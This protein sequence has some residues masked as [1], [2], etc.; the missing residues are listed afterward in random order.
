MTDLN[1]ACQII[2]KVFPKAFVDGIEDCGLNPI[3]VGL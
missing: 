2:K 3:R 1:G